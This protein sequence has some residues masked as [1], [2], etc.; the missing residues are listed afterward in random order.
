M[1]D[2]GA[3]QVLSA[4][5]AENRT[6]PYFLR[7]R[8]DEQ[9]LP[10]LFLQQNHTRLVLEADLRPASAHGFHGDKAQFPHADA[11]AAEREQQQV[12]ALLFALPRRFQQAGIFLPGK[13]AR[14]IQKQAAL[15]LS[16]FT[17]FSGQPQNSRNAFTAE[18]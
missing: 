18:R 17:R 5:R 2:I 9:P 8:I 10:Q 11:C 4:F 16:S 12:K 3:I 13:L 7:P 15:H 1:A 14:F 6:A